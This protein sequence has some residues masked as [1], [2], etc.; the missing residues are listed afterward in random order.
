M[1]L[2]NTV[3]FLLVQLSGKKTSVINLNTLYKRQQCV[4]MSE[5]EI[6]TNYK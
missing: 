1:N 2:L 6:C 5:I 3:N 4:N